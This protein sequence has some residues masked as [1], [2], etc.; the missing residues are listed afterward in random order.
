M[1]NAYAAACFTLDTDTNVA[2]L[3]ALKGSACA[4]TDDICVK[5]SAAGVP[6]TLTIDANLTCK[7]LNIGYGSVNGGS[8]SYGTCVVSDNV[9]ITMAASGKLYLRTGSRWTCNGTLRS[10][11]TGTGAEDQTVTALHANNQDVQVAGAWWQLVNDLTG[12]RFD[13]TASTNTTSVTCTT[14]PRTMFLAVG[15]TVEI[16]TRADGTLKATK[17]ISAIGAT[18][19]SW[20]SGNVSVTSGDSVYKAYA[21]T[22]KVYSMSGTTIT[23]GDGTASA[24]NNSGG[25]RPA[26]NDTIT[27]PGITLTCADMTY[28]NQCAMDTIQG[29]ID[30]T[31]VAMNGIRESQN[32]GGWNSHLYRYCIAKFAYTSFRSVSGAGIYGSSG[33]T[34]TLTNC[35]GTSSSGYGI[36]GLSG[37]TMTLTN[38]T[39]TSSSNY[40]I[41]G[42][43]GCTMTLTN[44]TGTS[45][46]GYGICGNYGCTMTLTN[47]TGTSSSGYGI[48][49]IYGCKIIA[50][51]GCRITGAPPLVLRGDVGG[52]STVAYRN[53]ASGDGGAIEWQ[54]CDQDLASTYPLASSLGLPLQNTWVTTPAAAIPGLASYGAA[55]IT[56]TLNGGTISTQFRC[57]HDYGATYTDWAELTTNTIDAVTPNAYGE[58]IQ[59]RVAKTD[60]GANMP[61]HSGVSIACTFVNGWTSPVPPTGTQN[62]PVIGSPVIRGGRQCQ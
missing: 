16:R 38:C 60:A 33:C 50:L 31:G 3:T 22:D 7:S 53:A 17:V 32:S 47:C 21:G 34:M 49:G 46:S 57:S 8:G 45:S 1:A 61:A 55:T 9:V 26:L 51:R 25:A 12:R 43:S 39:G 23:F 20:A 4:A 6:A 44:C 19:L 24:W 62:A 35:T 52:T 10:I 29:N 18:S 27:Q 5:A 56:T 59:F 37:C 2:G 13:V 48:C 14:D 40:G 15:D 42:N 41:Y 11:G 28:A 30:W 36:C 54:A 58:Y